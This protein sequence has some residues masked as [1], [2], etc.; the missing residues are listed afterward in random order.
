M[1]SV[2]GKWTAPCTASAINR[3]PLPPAAYPFRSYVDPTSGRSSRAYGD[4]DNGEQQSSTSS[5][6]AKRIFLNDGSAS[7]AMPVNYLDQD[8]RILFRALDDS[9]LETTSSSSSSHTS[10]TPSSSYSP[11]VDSYHNHRHDAHPLPTIEST[12]YE[13]P[14]YL[15]AKS[16]AKLS[17]YEKSRKV[18]EEAAA[19]RGREHRDAIYRRQEQL[20][21]GEMSYYPGREQWLVE[22]QR[23]RSYG[24][25]KPLVHD[26]YAAFLHGEKN[27][28]IATTTTA[29][30]AAAG[31]SKERRRK[32]TNGQ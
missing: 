18:M 6:D 8:E 16:H 26:T 11:F 30:T 10:S 22:W 14:L 2:S 4:D 23:V 32:Q 15:N 20:E 27:E 13:A 3:A 24:L 5:A 9:R 31:A 1:K 19:N 21:A 17:R 7:A 12:L 28:K 29:S 25:P